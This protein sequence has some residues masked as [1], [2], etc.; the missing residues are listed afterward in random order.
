MFEVVGQVGVLQASVVDNP[1]SED[2]H[3]VEAV[4]SKRAL[5]ANDGLLR[6]KPKKAIKR[7]L[8]RGRFF[9]K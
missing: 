2:I 3:S 5:P 4:F 8:K 6:N 9:I 1:A 7:V